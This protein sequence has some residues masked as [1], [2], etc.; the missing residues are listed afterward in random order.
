M[1]DHNFRE[2]HKVDSRIMLLDQGYL[3]EI[4]NKSE[5]STYGYYPNT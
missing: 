1:T 5:L 4:Q 2:M 3:K